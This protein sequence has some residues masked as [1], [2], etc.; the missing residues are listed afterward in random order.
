MLH[1]FT[2]SVE[3]IDSTPSLVR[4]IS[5]E[6]GRTMTSLHYTTC[7]PYPGVSLFLTGTAVVGDMPA[8]QEIGQVQKQPRSPD[9]P[10]LPGPTQRQ[11]FSAFRPDHDIFF[12]HDHFTRCVLHTRFNSEHHVLFNDGFVTGH[13]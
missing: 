13:V 9:R 3:K 6:S 7:Y 12:M 4:T 1:A 5:L 11:Q 10:H 8:V 2:L